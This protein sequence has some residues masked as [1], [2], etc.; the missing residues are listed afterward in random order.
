[1]EKNN[2]KKM[3]LI[4]G[5]GSP[6]RKELLG[7]LGV[8][9]NILTAD[10]EEHSD[11]GIPSAFAIDISEQKGK[12]V[13]DSI[14]DP[15]ETLVISSDTIVVLEDKIYG[16]PKD[17]E[18][19]KEMLLEL[20]GQTHEVITAVSF[21]TSSLKHS[22]YE[23]TKVTFEDIDPILLE[24]YLDT[25]ESLDKAGAYGIQG[26]SLFFISRIEGSYSNVVGFPLDRVLFELKEK[27]YWT[28]LN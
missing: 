23:S 9:F 10:L 6:R 8:P 15:S 17:R 13:L 18:N 3:Q 11:L 14:E 21:F 28:K 25:G 22:F 1:M 12:A 26:S 16:K 27:G 20:S 24:G 5:S 19:A 4:L 2:S 7:Y